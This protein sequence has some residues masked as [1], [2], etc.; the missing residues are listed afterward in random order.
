M[1]EERRKGEIEKKKLPLIEK[2][3][4]KHVDEEKGMRERK[5]EMEAEIQNIAKDQQGDETVLRELKQDYQAK[6]EVAKVSRK[7]ANGLTNK[8]DTV[9]KHV[10]ALSEEIERLRAS[11]TAEYEEKHRERVEQIGRT[12]EMV[13]DLGAQTETSSNHLHHP[14]ANT[15]EIEA[16]IMQLKA[17]KL[18]EN[19]KAKK[20]QQELK[21]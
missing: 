18:K 5:K 20:T 3:I 19:G 21:A 8:Q 9:Q 2:N 10:T 4:E 17:D 12:E 14:R 16:S 13:V 7:T 11:G 15:R 6:N 1:E